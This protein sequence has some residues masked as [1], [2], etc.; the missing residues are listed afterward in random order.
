MLQETSE[1]PPK[2]NPGSA[3]AHS[4]M[5]TVLIVLVKIKYNWASHGVYFFKNTRQIFFSYKSLWP[6]KLKVS[7]L[8]RLISGRQVVR[9][10]SDNREHH[11]RR[12][13]EFPF[14]TRPTLTFTI[15][16]K[17]FTPPPPHF[18]LVRVYDDRRN[19]LPWQY[20]HFP[21]MYKVYFDT[22][23]QW[24]AKNTILVNK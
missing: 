10:Y 15:I 3:P 20:R 23:F 21:N 19:G 1:L 18:N 24:E 11:E 16:T 17:N 7:I 5:I 13:Y 8:L 9:K 6:S 4:I 12:F 2:K 14:V 22:G